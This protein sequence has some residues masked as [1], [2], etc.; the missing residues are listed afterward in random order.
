[1]DATGTS[2]RDR[3][4]QAGKHLFATR[5]YE[6]TSTMM[7]ARTAATSESQLMK[8]FGSKDGLLEAI[9]DH[10]WTSMKDRFAAALLA[11]AP[12]ERLRRLLDEMIAWLDRDQEMKELMLL[13]S[14]R[15]KREG[16]PVLM[17]AGFLSFLNAIDTVLADMRAAGQLRSD[18]RPEVVRSAL[19]GMAE[20]MLRDQVVA[21]RMNQPP[22]CSSEE[23]RQMLE[24][25]LPALQPKQKAAAG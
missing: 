19:F 22:T 17:A 14:R 23:T 24:V 9:F 4:L 18:L 11:P 10:G 2:S 8:H 25:L 6:N 20:G 16:Q 5:G 12:V 15:L 7:I 3:L 13:E 21:R 1:M